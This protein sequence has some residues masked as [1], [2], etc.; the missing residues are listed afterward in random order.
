MKT[1]RIYLG[2]LLLLV[3]SISCKDNFSVDLSNQ[4]F[5]R[6]NKTSVSITAGEKYTIKANVDTLG[7]ANKTFNLSIL[8]PDI[9]SIEATEK[10]SAVITGLSGGSTVI[11]I[12]S[13]DGEIKYF[14]DLYVA[15]ERVIKILAIGNSFSDD[16]IEHYLYDLAKAS[17]H[18]VLIANLYFGGRSLQTHWERASSDGNDYQLRVISPDGSKNSFNDVSIRQAVE[19]ENWDYISFQEVSQLSGI[20][21]GYKEYLPQL[22]NFVKPLTSNPE[23]KFLLHQTWAY[24]QDS[25]HD[26]FANYNRDQMTMYN[27]IVDAVWKAKDMAKIYMVVPAGTTI[28]NGRTSYIGDKFTRDGYHLNLNIGRFAAS[29]AWF[30]ALFGGITENE[31]VPETLSKY[32]ADLAKTAAKEA[33]ANPKEVTALI[34]YKYPE[35]NE[36][37]LEQPLFIDFGPVKTEQVFN[38]FEKPGD[39]KLSNLKDSQGNNTNFAIEVVEAFQG[40]LER[41]LQNVL[42]MPRSVSE[43]MFFS[44]GVRF[45]KSSFSVS[46][47]NRDLKYTFVFYGSINDDKTETV[48]NVIGKNSGKGYLD[49]DNNLGKVVVIENIEPQEDATI[50]I[51]LGPGPN[52][53][54]WARFFGINAMLILPQGMPL[55]FTGNTSELKHPVFID[56]GKMD[57]GKPFYFYSEPSDAPRLGIQDQ[58]SNETGMSMS[59]TD[60]FS[61]ENQSGMTSNT[62]GLPVAFTQDAFWGNKGNPTGGFTV[63][64]M[65]S[66]KKYKFVFFGSRR[67]ATDN[68]ETKYLVQGT[69]EGSGLLNAANNNSKVVVID[70]IQPTLNGTVDINVSAGPNNNNPDGFYYINAMIITPEGYVMPGM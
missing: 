12:E 63:Y 55:P 47:L 44:D 59:V 19:G 28:Q 24:A 41:G 2:L 53:Q 68:R 69:N 39:G 66:T 57:A 42:G 46:N 50:T 18:K 29:C 48:F 36:F 58:M 61:G 54:Q 60:R 11:K 16:A 4:H 51:E 38:N 25:G 20:I 27:A 49:N 56:F 23:V 5:V 6:L 62:F 35:P 22:V 31:F 30:E 52:N 26:G 10:G 8:N 1:F 15:E 37:I 67:D 64:G 33:V 9:A 34:D 32:D 17:G 21:D 43:D 65:N 40:T 70:G 45:D 13:T 14:S 3:G 7:S